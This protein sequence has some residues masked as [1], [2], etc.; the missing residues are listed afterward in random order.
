MIKYGNFVG[1]DANV[2][3]LNVVIVTQICDYPENQQIIYFTWESCMIYEL[4]T[5]RLG[6]NKDR[7]G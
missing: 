4:I 5:I 2:L 1:E 6:I 3:K 7:K